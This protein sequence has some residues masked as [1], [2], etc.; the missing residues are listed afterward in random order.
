MRKFKNHTNT[1]NLGKSKIH[2]F[3]VVIILFVQKCEIF[4]TT[5]IKSFEYGINNFL[6][7][8]F[9]MYFKRLVLIKVSKMYKIIEH[10]A[11]NLHL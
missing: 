9:F 11:R 5:V 8:T 10:Y 4:W 3:I 1:I 7:S 2:Q 6:I